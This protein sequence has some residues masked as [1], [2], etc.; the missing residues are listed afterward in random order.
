LHLR[1]V[2]IDRSDE[3]AE[4]PRHGLQGRAVQDEAER[5]RRR[6]RPRDDLQE[7]RI[8]SL[9]LRKKLADRG[10]RDLR[11]PGQYPGIQGPVPLHPEP[12]LLLIH[13]PPLTARSPM[14]LFLASTSPRRQQLLKGVGYDFE[15]LKPGTEEVERK[16]ES[17]RKM[18]E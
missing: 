6:A 13:P 5:C 18:V 11:T 15:I 7:R 8:A 14:K 16:G 9:P 2:R 3:G 1:P 10:L 12:V 4:A 17:P